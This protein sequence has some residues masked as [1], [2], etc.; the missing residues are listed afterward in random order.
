M[1]VH[2]TQALGHENCKSLDSK[3]QTIFKQAFANAS[4]NVVSAHQIYVN[5]PEQR[6]FV[7]FETDTFEQIDNFFNPLLKRVLG[8]NNP[9]I[10]PDATNHLLLWRQKD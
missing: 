10:T 1:T 7:T 3:G 5:R 6:K 9:M 4:E 8:K 2:A